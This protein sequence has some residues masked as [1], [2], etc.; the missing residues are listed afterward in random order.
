MLSNFD[1]AKFDSA[2]SMHA[3]AGRRTAVSWVIAACRALPRASMRTL[4]AALP[5]RCTLCAAPSGDALLCPGCARQM[6]RVDAACPQCAL[7]S[8]ASATCGA[9]LAKPPAYATAT[10]AWTYAFPVDRLLQAFKYGG[11]LALAEP[12]ALALADRVRSAVLP[13]RLI[14]LPLSAQRQ[15]L[16][17]FNQ[18]HE[19]ARRVSSRLGIP[20]LHALRR[21]KDSPPQAGMSQELRRCN[22]RGAF[23]ATRSLDGLAVA[24]IDDVMTTGATLAAAAVAA[25]DAG[26]RRVD[27]WVVAR[28]LPSAQ[29][30]H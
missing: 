15:R 28:T 10:A 4:R 18:A 17:G 21:A 12:F 26:A 24:L 30:S 20:Q 29:Q 22:V 25:R 5:Q 1:A 16:R 7:P 19:I 23:E 8:P 6:P 13:D 14:A 9:C 2:A 3:I 27:V 11:S